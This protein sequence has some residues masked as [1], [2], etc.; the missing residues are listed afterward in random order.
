MDHYNHTRRLW[1]AGDVDIANLNVM[2]L[3]NHTFDASHTAMASISG[4][5]VSGTGWP[6]GGPTIAN[7]A[8]TTSSTNEATLDGDDISQTADGGTIGP[9]TAIVIYDATNDNPLYHYQF[10]STQEAGDGT[11]FNVTWHADGI[12]RW[13]APA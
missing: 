1:A 2:L 4:D 10:A 7:A 8:V 11:D 9:A 5:E 3:N 13:R 6:A 12:A